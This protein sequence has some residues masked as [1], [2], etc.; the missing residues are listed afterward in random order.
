[1]EEEVLT[2]LNSIGRKLKQFSQSNQ[3]NQIMVHRP[4]ANRPEEQN[5]AD[6]SLVSVPAQ[7][8]LSKNI[9]RRKSY[10][11]FCCNKS[12]AIKSRMECHVRTHT[13]DKPFRC[14]LCKKSYSQSGH[15]H[16]HMRTVHL[17]PLCSTAFS[18]YKKLKKHWRTHTDKKSCCCSICNKKTSCT[19]CNRSFVSK[20]HLQRHL[21]YHNSKNSGIQD[22]D[23]CSICHKSFR[24]SYM[25]RHMTAHW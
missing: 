13:G 12:F 24:S 1:M 22:T 18:G 3:I 7:G 25:K 2:L 17:C 10:S 8:R 9:G 5:L 23:L 19:F 6:T 21:Q 15:L 11:C 4:T 16:F 14:S 20:Y